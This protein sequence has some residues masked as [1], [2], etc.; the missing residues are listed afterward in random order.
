MSI[1]AIAFNIYRTVEVSLLLEKLL[2]DPHTYPDIY[3]LAFCQLL[4]NTTIAV[5]LF[6]AWI[7]VLALPA[8][9]CTQV[10]V[11]LSMAFI[12]SWLNC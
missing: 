12:F 7:K 3:F 4:Y 10:A 6:L 2:S 5:A 1:L 11:F 8:F 9:G